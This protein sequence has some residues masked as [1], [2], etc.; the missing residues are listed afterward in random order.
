MGGVSR[1]A[2]ALSRVH[3]LG[4]ALTCSDARAHAPVV[5]AHCAPITSVAARAG[6]RRLLHLVA[7]QG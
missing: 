5:L 1:Q 3:A 4:L 2:L 6:A 7:T